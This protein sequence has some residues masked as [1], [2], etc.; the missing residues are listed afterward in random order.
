MRGANL[1]GVSVSKTSGPKFF[2]LVRVWLLIAVVASSALGV[3]SIVASES[4]QESSA[5]STAYFQD[6]EDVQS[7]VTQAH[8]YGLLDQ[9]GAHSGDL[10]NETVLEVDSLLVQLAHDGPGDARSLAALFTDVREWSAGVAV[11]AQSS[12]AQ[13]GL[14]S[15]K[16]YETANTTLSRLID[17]SS[18]SRDSGQTYVILGIVALSVGCACL[19]AG[20]ILT[21]YRSHRVINIGLTL[22]LLASIGSIT[23]L[24]LYAS[25]TAAISTSDHTASRVVQASYHAWNS[26]RLDCLS[27]IDS[28]HSESHLDMAAQELSTAQALTADRDLAVESALTTLATLHD[29]IAG[30][31]G[32]DREKALASATSTWT[33]FQGVV[34]ATLNNTRPNPESLV[35]D[36]APYII[37]LV[38]CGLAGV[39][40]VLYGVHVRAKEYL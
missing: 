2:R 37:A 10:Y 22:A 13:P 7:T 19:L 25:N 11:D 5:Q 15:D 36:S 31:S 16:A 18:Q 17:E 27:S 30:T 32:V 40:S 4:A 1:L 26:L 34:D 12:Y 6:L 39:G 23:T 33:D 8:T 9:V 24:G 38:L 35:V 28:A 3:F 20:L 29:S 14:D 21:A